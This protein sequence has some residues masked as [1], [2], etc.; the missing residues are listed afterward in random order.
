MRSF[1]SSEWFVKKLKVK[2]IKCFLRYRVKESRSVVS[3]AVRGLREESV[4]PSC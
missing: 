3:V 2:V 1:T 4:C